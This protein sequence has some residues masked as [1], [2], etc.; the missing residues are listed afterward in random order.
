ME[1]GQGQMCGFYL[2]TA[3]GLDFLTQC[4]GPMSWQLRITFQGWCKRIFEVETAREIGDAKV[5]RG[6]YKE[7]KLE[8]PVL[9]TQCRNTLT[10]TGSGVAGRLELWVFQ[11]RSSVW[12]RK[13]PL[14][15]EKTVFKNVFNW[16]AIVLEVQGQQT[17]TS[18]FLQFRFG[19]NR[20]GRLA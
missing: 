12:G 5:S 11:P 10:R 13:T 18:S 9:G 15:K 20:W 14:T 3:E 1:F 2:T 19:Q 16:E 17:P 6:G 7:E 8:G 4:L